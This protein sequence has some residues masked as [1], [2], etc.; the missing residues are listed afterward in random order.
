MKWIVPVHMRFLLVTL[1][2]VGALAAV[3]CSDESEDLLPEGSVFVGKVS[4]DDQVGETGRE[5]PEPIVVR[6]YDREGNG[7]EGETVTFTV[8]G[9]G[10]RIVSAPSVVT[11]PG[12][13]ASASWEL[14]A[15]PVWNRVTAT[16]EGGQAEF[17]AWANPGE[18]P[19]LHVVLEGE[20]LD[21]AN[22]DLAF[23]EGRGLFLGSPGA[24]LNMATP[25]SVAEELPLTGETVESPAGIA[26]GP[27]GDLYI[28]ENDDPNT[29]LK[30]VRPS[31]LCEILSDGFGDEP[32]AL[33]NYVAVHSSGE[34]YLSST[35]DDRIYRISP[36]TGE[37]TAFLS[38]PGPNGLAF[39]A[40]ETY[41]YILTEN[42]AVFCIP[43]PNAWGGL[44]RVPIDPDGNPGQLEALVEGFALAGDG[45]AFDEEGN[46]YVVFSVPLGAGLKSGVFVYTPD[47]RFN[48]F[49]LVNIL[50]GDIVTNIAFGVDPFDPQS[51]YGYGF[52]GRLY[53]VEVGIRGLSLP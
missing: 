48:A 38:I 13:K 17:T 9:G 27:A 10:G 25:E 52:T 49:F 53:R 6:V 26:F 18:Q 2:L 35:C 33:P 21:F 43:S 31:G 20:G 40:Q 37:T 44:F 46:L 11:D 32:F 22:E 51:L 42:P 19:E 30:R 24:I 4:G 3:G 41:L 23:R 28:C 1:G 39:D 50:Q 36:D 29:A 8:T 7:I 34:I 15:P 12:G 5:L 14:G 47:G 16:A 45:L